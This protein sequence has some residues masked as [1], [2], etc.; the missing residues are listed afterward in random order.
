[1]NI[2]ST[3]KKGLLFILHNLRKKEIIYINIKEVLPKD[4]LTGRVALI[5]GG[6]GGI[7]KAIAKAFVK[8]GCVVVIAGRNEEKLAQG[9]LSVAGGCRCLTKELDMIAC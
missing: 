4:L 3:I 6:G 7:G 5:T 8:C 9:G 1:M 2:K